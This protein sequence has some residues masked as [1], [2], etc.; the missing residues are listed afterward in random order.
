MTP[1]TY[2]DA[3]AATNPDNSEDQ[4]KESALAIVAGT[5]ANDAYWNSRS[6]LEAL[7]AQAEGHGEVVR[8]A[9][10]NP[11]TVAAGPTDAGGTIEGTAVEEPPTAIG[12][13]PAEP[14]DSDTVA[15]LR[16]QL[17]DAGINPDA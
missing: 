1:I 16:K 5:A 7:R 9:S 12:G 17:Q 11:P 3:Y 15:K 8:D 4:R 10:S 2:N 14:N 13:Q 6:E